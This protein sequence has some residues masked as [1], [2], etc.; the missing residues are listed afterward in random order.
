VVN[1][2]IEEIF[3]LRLTFYSVPC[4]LSTMNKAEVIKQLEI[5]VKAAGSQSHFCLTHDVDRGMV[6][7]VLA[8]KLDPPP[9][10]LRVLGL[11]KVEV[12][13]YRRLK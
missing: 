2:S 5:W 1:L 7:K 8:G 4:Y 11:E 12:V 10:V 13:S 9:S 6:S 3:N